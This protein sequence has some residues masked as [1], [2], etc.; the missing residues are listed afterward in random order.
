MSTL[1]SVPGVRI[2][3]VA[4]GL[5][6]VAGI[7]A[8]AVLATTIWKSSPMIWAFAIGLAL[9]PFVRRSAV[10][11][12]S[13]TEFSARVLLRVGVAMLGLG[14]SLGQ[15]LSIGPS[16]IAI[17]GGTILVTLCAA[18]W[19]G[20]QAKVDRDLSLLI[21]MG[22]AVCGASAIAATSAAIR[23]DRAST[24]YAI[25]IAT[26]FGTVNMLLLP[27][28]AG[29]LGL[30][31]ESAGMWIGASIQEVAQV[32]VAGAAISIAT[33]NVATLVKL[34]R[35]ALLPVALVAVDLFRGRTVDPEPGRAKP[36]AVPFFV[37]VFVLL[38]VIRSLVPVPEPLLDAVAHTAVILQAAALAAIG[39]Q[40]DFADLKERGAT[41]LLL[42][43]GA[44]FTAV[45]FSLLAVLVLRGA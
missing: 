12:G 33:L 6:V 14:I 17:A 21:A 5:I 11:T 23:S 3:A 39:L 2:R 22:S 43:L 8:V 9:A 37:L 32:T 34:A 41:P 15:A 4:P 35:V 44:S 36:A 25:A 38:M 40:V 30:S 26:L 45:T 13:G 31:R 7:T 20:R 27:V 42:G 18:V 28:L 29:L 19:L 24:G 10:R 1:V 16:G